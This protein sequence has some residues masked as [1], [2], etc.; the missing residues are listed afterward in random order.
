MHWTASRRVQTDSCQ[1]RHIGGLTHCRAGESQHQNASERSEKFA[2]M[3][4]HT[5]GNENEILHISY[6]LLKLNAIVS[7]ITFI[8]F[9]GFRVFGASI[10]I[11]RQ[12]KLGQLQF[13][14]LKAI[15]L[16]LQLTSSNFEQCQQ[17]MALQSCWLGLP[18]T[19]WFSFSILIGSGSRY[20]QSGGSS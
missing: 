12:Q 14:L 19:S 11:S 1:S 13:R 4:R 17:H 15:H 10:L 3:N 16:T 9:N 20:L 6:N 2:E 18:K 5:S 7:D 8:F